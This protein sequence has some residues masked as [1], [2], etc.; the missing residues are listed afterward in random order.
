MVLAKGNP[1]PCPADAINDFVK[2][3]YRAHRA[4]YLPTF[5]IV[6]CLLGI[7]SCVRIKTTVMYDLLLIDRYEQRKPYK[8][9]KNGLQ[10][11]IKSLYPS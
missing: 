9:Y 2:N 7:T 4:T 11:W 6:V 5:S 1:C 10:E 8:H 3:Y